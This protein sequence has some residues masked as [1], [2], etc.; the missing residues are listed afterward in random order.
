MK[1]LAAL[2]LL[3]AG[4]TFGAGAATASAHEF[5]P[6]RVVPVHRH[7]HHVHVHPWY[8]PVYRPVFRPVYTPAP[9]CGGVMINT[10]NYGIGYGW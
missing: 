3:V 10:P 2:A 1:K 9:V 7:H 4:L 8:R 5:Y 6:I